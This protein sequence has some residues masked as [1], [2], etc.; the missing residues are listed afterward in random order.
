MS[1]SVPRAAATAIT[2]G[3]PELTITFLGTGTSTGVPMLGCTCAVCRSGDLRNKR[4]RASI[5]V[6]TNDPNPRNS[7]DVPLPQP[8]NLLVDTTPEMRLQL[9]REEV[10]RLEAVLM[11]HQHADHIFGMDDIRQFNYRQGVMPIYSNHAT[12]EQL[13]IV[14]DYCFRV[15]Q[16]GG[17][18]PQLDLR[19][20]EP[21]QPVVIA[22]ITVLPLPVWHGD[23]KI[24]AYKFGNRFA[25]VTDVSKI[26]DETRPHLHGLDTLILDAVRYDPHP[27]HFHVEQ[28]LAEIADLR[29]RRTYLTHLS[30]AFDH[31]KADAQ[32][33]LYVR[34]GYDGLQFTVP[35]G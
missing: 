14:F 22:G 32:L 17:G 4:M 31:Q 10:G 27:T 6:S 24:L 35:A 26:P 7:G 15:G 30:H 21:F 9:L 2:V 13:E 18:K 8:R 23:L 28:A 19:T 20:L 25:Y 1:E 16:V 11:T 34:L 3:S 5:L 12:R 29:P 33:P